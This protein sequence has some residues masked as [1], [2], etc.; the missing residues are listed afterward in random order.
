M[1]KALSIVIPSHNRPDLLRACLGSILRHVPPDTEILVV[2]D[3]SPSETISRAASESTGVRVLRLP[4]RRGFCTAVNAGIAATTGAIVELLNDDTE[5]TEGWGE[6]ALAHFRDP[7]VG[8]VAPLVLRPLPS[9]SSAAVIDSAGDGYHA[10]GVARKR[11]HGRGLAEEYLQGRCVFGASGSSAFY[12]RSALQEAG[13]FPESFGAYFEDV[14]LSFR[15]H[16]AGYRI[17]YEPRS[18]VFH[19]GSSSHGTPRRRLLEQQSRNEERVFWRNLP[20]RA[21]LGA[22]P[23]HAAVLL[24]K[25]WLRWHEGSLLPF[26]CGRMRLLG[27]IPEL[28]RHRRAL[29]Q[30][31]PTANPGTWELDDSL[32]FSR[33]FR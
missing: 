27:E 21:L 14:D 16:W 32:D 3:G 28:L 2:D 8:A 24:G 13:G 26:L 10:G 4:K 31:A 5:V 29:H 9:S 19:H 22:L 12:R 25:A 30:L 1:C 17:L 18:R 11:G 7:A 33:L 20:G 15:L 6:A 23:A